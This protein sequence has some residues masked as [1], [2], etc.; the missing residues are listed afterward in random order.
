MVEKNEV[1]IGR[2][3]YSFER[4]EYQE[5]GEELKTIALVGAI[6][7]ALPVGILVGVALG[8]LWGWL[9]GVVAGGLAFTIYG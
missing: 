4:I 2:E 8:W 3:E 6:A 5:F 1:C 9:V 7:F